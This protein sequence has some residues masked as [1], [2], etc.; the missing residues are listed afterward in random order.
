M[1]RTS[2][3]RRSAARSRCSD[4]WRRARSRCPRDRRRDRSPGRARARV[5]CSRRAR[6]RTWVSAYPGARA[7]RCWPSRCRSRRRHDA[8][9]GARTARRCCRCSSRPSAGARSRC[10]GR[11]SSPTSRRPIA[12][13]GM[14]LVARTLGWDAGTAAEG[15]GLLLV[16]AAGFALVGVRRLPARHGA[17][18]RARRRGGGAQRSESARQV[19][20]AVVG[21]LQDGLVIFAP[22]RPHRACQR[23]DAARSRGSPQTELV[24]ASAPL[25]VLARRAV[26]RAAHAAAPRSSRT[27][28]GEFD[29]VLARKSGER[30][31]AIV[32]VG[33]TPRRLARG[34][35]SRTSAERAKLVAETQAAREAFARSAEVIGEYLYSGEREADEGFVMH[36]RGPGLAALLGAPRGV[37]GAGRR[38][39]RLRPSGRSPAARFAWRFAD[40]I[41]R[42]GE[43]VQQ[44]YR[45][46]GRGRGVALGARP[47][48]D[49][50]R[51]TAA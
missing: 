19:S 9:D 50:R 42:D 10:R 17:A 30:F 44:D 23:A 49:H 20:E 18:Q 25:P 34:R 38:L 37:R 21:A 26:G 51:S 4:S 13:S 32:T 29:V 15:L 16:S 7:G 45:L 39:R 33:V 41:G 46:V 11:L 24:G 6:S 1:S 43:I 8:R 14:P 5:R 12:A 28:R 36:A 47:R 31:P 27:G 3:R 48:R 2:R 22:G 40:L 35:R